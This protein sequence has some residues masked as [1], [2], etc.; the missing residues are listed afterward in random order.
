[1]YL[2]E[3]LSVTM[4]Y[5]T[6]GET[7]NH[8]ILGE[9][10]SCVA[11]CEVMDHPLVKCKLEKSSPSRARAKDSMG[12]DVPDKYFVVTNSELVRLKYVLVFAKRRST[13]R[14]VTIAYLLR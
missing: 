4:P 1:M 12:G 7:W 9:Q 8:S 14:C 5:T 11:M 13:K 6:S 2:S 3:D 10:L